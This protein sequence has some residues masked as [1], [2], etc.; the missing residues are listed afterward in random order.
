MALK[1]ELKPNERFI[2]G[3]CVVTNHGSRTRL[4][5]EG[6][7]PILREKDIM[8]LGAANTSAQRL[9]FVVQQ[10][11]TSKRPG[12]FQ[13]AYRRLAREITRANPGAGPF[14]ERINNR[15]LTGDFYKA[16]KEARKLIAYEGEYL[17]MNYASKAYAKVAKETARPRELEANLLLKAAA[18]LQAVHDSWRD[19]PQGLND[20]LMYNRRLWTVFIDAVARPDNKL[21][22]QVRQNIASLGM[23]VMGETFSLMTNPRPDHLVSLIKVNRRIATGL[24][25]K[26]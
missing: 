19:K 1:L 2:L 4:L 11:Y 16:L 6:A 24:R 18:Q 8:T 23:F 15:I 20:A 13:V 10:M 26:N 9:Y 3:D 5:I 17:E 12:E 21:P 22:M 14:I 25:S 7:V